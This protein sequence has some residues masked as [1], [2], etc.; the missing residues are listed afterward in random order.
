MMKNCVFRA[1]VTNLGLYNEGY[2]VGEW[3]SFPLEREGMTFD[4]SINDMLKRIKV[5]GKVYEEYFITDYESNVA[6]LTESFGE[7]ENLRMLNRLAEMI[8]E[9]DISFQQLESM[10]EYGESTRSV[11]E[12]MN[13]VYSADCFYFMPDVANDYD[14]GYEYAEESGMFTEAFET[15][16]VLRNYIDYESYG[17][18]I[19]LEEGGIHTE[20]GYI[21]LTDSI[22]E[23]IEEIPA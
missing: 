10:I 7:Y 22:K 13:L 3:V 12:L 23:Y 9:S 14:L 11:E 4:E 5:D 6:G 2:L 21:S 16:G 17:R 1:Y 8:V 18:D 19:R 20:H 15:L